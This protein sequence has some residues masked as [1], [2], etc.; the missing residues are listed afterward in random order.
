MPRRI[1]CSITDAA[2][3]C[4]NSLV[5]ERAMRLAK[6]QAGP[7]GIAAQAG[8]MFL[9]RVHFGISRGKSLQCSTA[10]TSLRQALAYVIAL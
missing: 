2:A 9:W 5:L 1:C 6:R 3:Y 4:G 8:T 10:S 7:G